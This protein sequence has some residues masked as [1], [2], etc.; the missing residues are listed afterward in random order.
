MVRP[1]TRGAHPFVLLLTTPDE[2][3]ALQSPSHPLTY[4]SYK[5]LPVICPACGTPPETAL[6]GRFLRL[7][8]KFCEKK[9]PQ[10]PLQSCKLLL[11]VRLGFSDNRRN[12]LGV[13]PLL[14]V[15]CMPGCNSLV[16]QPPRPCLDPGFGPGETSPPWPALEHRGYLK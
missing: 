8:P 1:S 16:H 12:V 11:A 15:Y 2:Q 10:N 9:A 13:V 4:F 5:S 6:R 14:W 3:F 7:A